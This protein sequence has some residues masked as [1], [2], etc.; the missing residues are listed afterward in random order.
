MLSCWATLRYNSH[1]TVKYCTI[2]PQQNWDIAGYLFSRYTLMP[3]SNWVFVIP[4]LFS[5]HNAVHSSLIL[6]FTKYKE[7]K[8]AQT[9]CCLPSAYYHTSMAY[10]M[11]SAFTFPHSSPQICII[12]QL[13][14]LAEITLTVQ[15]FIKP[16]WRE[17]IRFHSDLHSY[18]T[19]STWTHNMFFH[20]LKY[21]GHLA[22]LPH[23][24]YICSV[25]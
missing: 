8:P 25:S 24:Q 15:H 12:I 9:M 4:Y 2:L 7:T 20:L 21:Y 13:E 10:S 23:V 19:L 18:W 22:N 17:I 5:L 14:Y 6:L 1:T 11:R 3:L 16:T